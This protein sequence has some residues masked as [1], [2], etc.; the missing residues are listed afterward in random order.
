M[1]WPNF[2]HLFSVCFSSGGLLY[3]PLS[4]YHSISS[5][6][7]NSLLLCCLPLGL[8]RLPQDVSAGVSHTLDAQKLS[9]SQHIS[10]PRAG[11]RQSGSVGELQQ[12]VQGVWCHTIQ[13]ANA[14]TSSALAARFFCTKQS[15]EV[16][17]DGSHDR[18]VRRVACPAGSQGEVTQEPCPPLVIEVGQQFIA[19]LRE[20]NPNQPVLSWRHCHL[21]E[22]KVIQF[23]CRSRGVS[24]L[25]AH[26]FLKK[27]RLL[28]CSF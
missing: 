18:A 24:K 13:L 28:L 3:Y 25:Q 19:V 11:D 15:A 6:V 23:M 7:L 9:P 26:F 2:F 27:D 20:G 10:H 21:H 8:C 4:P 14:E 5:C 16:Q 1:I 12:G 17:T 22:R